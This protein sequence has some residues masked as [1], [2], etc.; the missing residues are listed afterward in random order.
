MTEHL[1][2]PESTECYLDGWYFNRV[3]ET[4]DNISLNTRQPITIE[5]WPQSET[6][7]VNKWNTF[8]HNLAVSR[9]VIEDNSTDHHGH[10]QIR[11]HTNSLVIDHDQKRIYRLEPITHVAHEHHYQRRINEQLAKAYTYLGIS[12]YS[13]SLI[14]QKF[15]T[16]SRPLN[17]NEYGYCVAEAIWM[18]LE[19]IGVISKSMLNQR[20]YVSYLQATFGLPPGNPDISYG[21][22]PVLVGGLG[23]AAVGGLLGGGLTGVAVGGAIGALG[24]LAYNAIRKTK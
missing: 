20:K 16:P 11:R 6:L 2:F 9:L 7:T 12:D 21:W 8:T 14:T 22:T 10:H 23:G 24:G 4:V 13:Q 15:M 3:L 17:C 18:T 19:S 1:T 5:L